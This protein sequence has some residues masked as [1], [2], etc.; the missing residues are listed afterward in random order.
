MQTQATLPLDKS[1]I[2]MAISKLLPQRAEWGRLEQLGSHEP[3]AYY[4]HVKPLANR[5][6]EREPRSYE[7]VWFREIQEHY[8][9]SFAEVDG[10]PVATSEL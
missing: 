6:A 8:H 5:A 7:A 10:W 4:N 3:K 2:G 9:Y 1:E